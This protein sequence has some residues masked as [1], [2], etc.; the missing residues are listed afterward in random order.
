MIINKDIIPT[1]EIR[2]IEFYT[3]IYDLTMTKERIFDLFKENDIKIVEVLADD[4]SYCKYGESV[5]LIQGTELNLVSL[6][7][8]LNGASFIIEHF[9]EDIREQ[10]M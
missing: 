3:A 5:Y 2:T 10:N 6:F 9:L 7:W 8:T 4:S 1:N